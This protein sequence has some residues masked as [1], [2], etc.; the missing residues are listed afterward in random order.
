[1]DGMI[2]HAGRVRRIAAGRAEIAVAT[3][4]CSSCG[5]VGG[6]GIGK[7]AG[8][9]GE[10]LI[11]LAATPGLR[12]GDGVTLELHEAQLTRAALFGYLLPAVCLIAGALIGESAGANVGAGG[13]AVDSLAPLGAVAGLVL[14]LALTRLRRPLTPRLSRSIF[15]SPQENPHV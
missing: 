7:L 8:T 6:C 1:M 2:A 5:H 3:G 11:D 12:V 13:T 10:T 4:G 14:G 9:R 15:V